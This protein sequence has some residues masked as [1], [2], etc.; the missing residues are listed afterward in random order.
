M[1]VC[2]AFAHAAL[3]CVVLLLTSLVEADTIP[4][5][6]NPGDVYHRAF[7]TSASYI[8]EAPIYP[9]DPGAFSGLAGADFQVTQAAYDAGLIPDWN[10]I[11]IVWHAIL[12]DET[13]NAKDHVAITGPVYNM[14]NELIATDAADM[15]DGSLIHAILYDELGQPHTGVD[16]AVHTGSTGFGTRIPGETANSW[17]NQGGTAHYGVADSAGLE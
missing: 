3:V 12:S 10:G 9:P 4:P 1:H 13:I 11:D 14:Q 2:R 16:S 7:V 6:L 5:G 15:W 8:V 17:T